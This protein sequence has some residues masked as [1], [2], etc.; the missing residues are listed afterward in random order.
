MP[1]RCDLQPHPP[2]PQGD[3]R[4]ENV[5]KCYKSNE[6]SKNA[7]SVT[8][9]WI[10]QRDS[11]KGRFGKCV[12]HEA[13]LVKKSLRDSERILYSDCFTSGF[14]YKKVTLSA[15]VRSIVDVG[16]KDRQR[17]QTEQSHTERKTGF[18]SKSIPL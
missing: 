13:Q 10:L 16:H 17:T 7:V 6:T 14:I 1:S 4:E 15:P 3:K 12:L 2:L 5:I 11:T 18:L 8:T 9:K